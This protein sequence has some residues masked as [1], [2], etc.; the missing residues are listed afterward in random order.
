VIFVKVKEE[1]TKFQ[2]EL[3]KIE[4]LEKKRKKHLEEMCTFATRHILD[5]QLLAAEPNKGWRLFVDRNTTL[6]ELEFYYENPLHLFIKELFCGIDRRECHDPYTSSRK[7]IRIWLYKHYKLYCDEYSYKI[8]LAS[9]ERVDDVI[10]FCKAVK[11]KIDSEQNQFVRNYLANQTSI[12][13]WLNR[14]SS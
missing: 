12:A 11:I 3:R 4:T 1:I 6:L 7:G 10:E 5:K 14:L 13:Y 9:D 8:Y 2:Q